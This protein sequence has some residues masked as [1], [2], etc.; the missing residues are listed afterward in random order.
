MFEHLRGTDKV[1]N[2][3]LVCTFELRQA[4]TTFIGGK[5]LGWSADVVY[6]YIYDILLELDSRKCFS[7]RTRSRLVGLSFGN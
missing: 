4:A 5:Q 7:A 3:T 1:D 2:A 6:V